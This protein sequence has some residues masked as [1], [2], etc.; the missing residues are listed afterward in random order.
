M[1][2][3]DLNGS[4]HCRDNDVAVVDRNTGAATPSGTVCRVA[5]VI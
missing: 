4:D 1:T 5:T 2:P 3:F